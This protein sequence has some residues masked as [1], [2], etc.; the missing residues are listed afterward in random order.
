MGENYS[1]AFALPNEVWN[2]VV[3]Y[4]GL[5]EVSSMGKVKSVERVLSDGRLWE[6]RILKP[7]KNKGGYLIV[8]LSKNGKRKVYTIHRLV[9]LAFIPNDT[10]EHKTQINHLNEV[11]TNN[12]YLNLSWVTPKENANWGTRTERASKAKT[13]GKCSKPVVAIN[14]YTGKVVVEF[15][16]M[17]EA[18][19]NGYNQGVVSLCC[20]G[21]KEMHKGLIWVYKDKI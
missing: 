20:N 18:E 14:P 7:E 10:P 11:K 8:H 17:M 3:G 12:H 9:A 6:E 19:R 15:P 13:N 4:E 16:S 5:Y 1:K 2:P 21:K